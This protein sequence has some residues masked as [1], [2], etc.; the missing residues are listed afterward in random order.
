VPPHQRHQALGSDAED[1]QIQVVERASQRGVANAA[2]HEEC[3]PS[4]RCYV[5]A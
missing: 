5:Q 3:T 2:P 1:L 4:G